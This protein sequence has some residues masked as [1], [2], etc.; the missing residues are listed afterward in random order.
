M[1]VVLGGEI[2]LLGSYLSLIIQ[3]TFRPNNPGLLGHRFPLRE[4]QPLSP[5]RRYVLFGLKAVMPPC[6][7]LGLIA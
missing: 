7:N 2:L 3:L 4:D 1:V 6:V 5:P